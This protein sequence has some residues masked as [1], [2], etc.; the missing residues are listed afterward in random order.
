MKEHITISQLSQ[1]MNVS[2]HQLRYFEE[3]GILYPS[4]TEKNQYRMYGLDEIYQL[5]H[6]LLL[7]KLNVPVAQIEECLTSY[8]ADD[9]NQLLESSLEKVRDEIANLKQLEQFIHKVLNEHHN[10][11][12]QDNE[13]RIRLLG[14]RYLKLSGTNCPHPHFY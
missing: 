11:I 1:L 4:Y 10:S 12:Q 3:K 2:V 6:I 5:S 14:P 9:Y 7:R 8:T 13:Y